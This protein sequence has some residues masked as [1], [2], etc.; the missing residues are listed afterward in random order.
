MHTYVATIAWERGQDNF[1]DNSYSRG[2]RWSFDGGVEVPASSSPSVVPEP[3]SVAA[4][5]DP[6]EAFVAAISSC[7]MLTFL[8]LAGKAGFVVDRYVDEAVGVMKRNEQGR[9][10]V[11]RVAL[12][13]RIAFGGERQPTAEELD[14]LHHRAHEDC[15]IANSV[16]TEIVVEAPVETG[17]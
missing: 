15:F 11:T 3:M 5:V 4:A 14:D 2:H 6:E 7:H 9:V 17:A 13:P 8:W 12:R 10:A 1:K 16:K